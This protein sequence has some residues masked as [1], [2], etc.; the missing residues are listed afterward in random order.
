MHC[1]ISSFVCK[2]HS[3]TVTTFGMRNRNAADSD[4]V[5]SFSD[6]AQEGKEDKSH[7]T[8]SR[9]QKMLKIGLG[10]AVLYY[11]VLAMETGLGSVDL[12]MHAEKGHRHTLN[13]LK[14][15][16]TVVINTFKRPD[17]LKE[18]IQHYSQCREAEYIY[19]VWSEKEKPNPKVVAEY[20]A[21]E[22][23]KVYTPPSLEHTCSYE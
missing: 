6:D 13:P 21:Q 19:V 7:P 22:S 10:V 11:L 18:A 12:E 5:R 23:P 2:N 3:F 14:M 16:Y 8:P 9:F 20:S 17:R 1:L 15:H 4:L